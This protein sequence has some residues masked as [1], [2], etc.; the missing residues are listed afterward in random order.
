LLAIDLVCIQMHEKSLESKFLF[1]DSHHLQ[2]VVLFLSE[3]NFLGS[4]F[5]PQS[6]NL[7]VAVEDLEE[8]QVVLLLALFVHQQVPLKKNMG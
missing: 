8:G 2:Q 6:E 3:L 4:K 1:V 7:F 5:L